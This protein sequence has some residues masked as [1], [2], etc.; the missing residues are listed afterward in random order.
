M[1]KRVESRK[2]KSK[3]SRRDSKVKKV[4]GDVDKKSEEDNGLS[5][6][7]KKM[8]ERWKNMQKTTTPFIHP[9]R[10][11]MK[12]LID[13]QNEEVGGS[14][15]DNIDGQNSTGFDAKNKAQ[16]IALCIHN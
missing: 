6:E 10:K 12:E 3:G 14:Q 16:V 13:I 9:I 11:H 5:A 1:A 4:K 15:C 8:L 7:D 2:R